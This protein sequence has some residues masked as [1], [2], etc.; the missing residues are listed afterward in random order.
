MF[1]VATDFDQEMKILIQLSKQKAPANRR[2]GFAQSG[3]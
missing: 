2:R 3:G 1:R